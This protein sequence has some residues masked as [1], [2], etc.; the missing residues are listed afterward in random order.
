MQ[1]AYVTNGMNKTANMQTAGNSFQT[2]IK[3]MKKVLNPLA[4]YNLDGLKNVQN[5]D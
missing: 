3:T 5:L 1:D 2:F 4:N